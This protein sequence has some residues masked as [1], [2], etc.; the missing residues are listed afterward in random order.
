MGSPV[1][2]S[3]QADREVPLVTMRHHFRG[4]QARGL[5]STTS[6]VAP[7]IVHPAKCELPGE[8]LCPGTLEKSGYGLSR[9]GGDSDFGVS[10]LGFSL[11]F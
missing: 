11:G 8:V 2:S 9:P 6:L 1:G 10:G 3:H 4:A 5:N 7:P